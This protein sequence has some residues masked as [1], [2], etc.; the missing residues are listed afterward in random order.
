M[1]VTVIIT[2]TLSIIA[3]VMAVLALMPVIQDMGTDQGGNWDDVLETRDTNCSLLPLADQQACNEKQLNAE[4]SI[5]SRDRT[6][7]AII[8][9]PVFLIGAIVAWAFLAVTRRDYG[10]V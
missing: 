7:S 3:T 1:A 4:R 6:F 2:A 10:E 8:V 9:L 5:V